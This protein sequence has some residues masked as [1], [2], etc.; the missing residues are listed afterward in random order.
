MTA[1]NTDFR[2]TFCRNIVMNTRQPTLSTRSSG[3]CRDFDVARI[4]ASS[5]TVFGATQTSRTPD[6]DS[7]QEIAQSLPESANLRIVRVRRKLLR[8]FD[9]KR[10]ISFSSSIVRD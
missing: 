10:P 5:L 9:C 3:R 2:V 7:A 6:F 1:G 4:V 8:M